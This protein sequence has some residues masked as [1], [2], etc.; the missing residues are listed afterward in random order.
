ML[1]FI[2]GRIILREMHSSGVSHL[3]ESLVR[4]IAPHFLIAGAPTPTEAL[5]PYSVASL[6]FL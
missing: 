6:S 1:A 4:H 5:L 3:Q 2:P